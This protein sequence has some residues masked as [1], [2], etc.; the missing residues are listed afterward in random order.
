M[1]IAILGFAGQGQSSFEHWNTSD[2]Q[3]TICDR[4]ITI[5]I[6][7]GVE[8][9]LG[10]AYLENLDRFDLLIRTPILHPRDIV[11]ANPET[12]DI[13]DKVWSN[14]NEF[15]KV[16]P[17][18]N[19]IGVTGTKGKGTTSTLITRMLHEA[20]A[21]QRSV[22]L[23]GNIGIPPLELLKDDI[24][25]SD[26]VVLEL[27]NFQLI[28]LKASP[29]I[30]V[31]LM[32]EPEHMDWHE[33]LDE[34]I[35]AKQQLFMQQ[36]ETDIAVYYADN[37]NS[38]SV[39]DATEGELIPYFK[40][41]G[42]IV[43]NGA[44]VIDGQEICK[45]DELKLL[46]KHNWQNACAATTAVWQ[47]TQSVQ[48]LHKALTSFSGLP[49]RIELRDTKNGVRYYNDS[50]ATAPGAAIAAMDAV[51]GKKVMIMGGFDR[52]LEL[53]ELAESLLDAGDDIR[54]VVLIGASAD[55][56]EKVF[57][58]NGFTNF[59]HC[60]E[61][62]MPSIV[63]AA[64]AEAQDGDAVVLS[65]AFASFDMFKNFEERGNKFNEAV[66]GL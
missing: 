53:Q 43:Q 59:I 7:K 35:S 15:L 11:A 44:I 9:Q 17:T 23:G 10:D 57:A 28:D 51:P 48:A 61:K 32:V 55:R 45:T 5:A 62:D 49:F 33:D 16:C 31:C 42:A 36:T 12:P 26:W 37:E 27:A 30:G 34:Y 18:K 41:P 22:H 56:A 13:L 6:P 66:A 20:F 19:V 40:Q 65:P 25:S 14:T 54:K 21:G 58:A 8:S 50:F 4:D 60:R 46:G 29:H 63:H 24:Q 2:N 64:T 1:N 3:V 38:L 39:A 52:G 47:I